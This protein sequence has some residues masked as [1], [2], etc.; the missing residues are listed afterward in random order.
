MFKGLK[1][2]CDE[3]TTICDKSQYGE[4]SLLERIKLNLHF[5]MCKICIK[6]TKQNSTM[7]QL[8]KMK[9]KDCKEHHHCMSNNDKEALKKQLEEFNG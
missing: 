4:S 9:A 6:Y 2:T 5:L 8:F 1:I 7:T 3:A